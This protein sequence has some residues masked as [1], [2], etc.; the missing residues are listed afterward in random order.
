MSRNTVSHA[1][2]K[3]LLDCRLCRE[4]CRPRHLLPKTSSCSNSTSCGLFRRQESLYKRW[5]WLA[6]ARHTPQQVVAYVIVGGRGERTYRRL[7]WE[8]IPES[9]KGGYCYSDFSG[10]LIGRLSHGSAMRRWARKAESWRMWSA[11]TTPCAS[12]WLVLLEDA[13]FLRVGRDA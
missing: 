2:S 7:L 5:V 9:Y 1:G 10:R 11:G 8:R 4:P 6:L 3:K 12:V 13:L